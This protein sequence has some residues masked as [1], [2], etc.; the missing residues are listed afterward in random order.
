[1]TTCTELMYEQSNSSG[2]ESFD[3]INYSESDNDDWISIENT[4]N[5]YDLNDMMSIKHLSCLYPDEI[6]NMLIGTGQRVLPIIELS[7]NKK[8]NIMES[9]NIEADTQKRIKLRREFLKKLQPTF[10]FVTEQSDDRSKNPAKFLEFRS[11]F[12]ARI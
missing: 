3:E 9:K 7:H 10:L 5:I 11:S 1:M 4:N 6:E 8:Y 2:D 12:V